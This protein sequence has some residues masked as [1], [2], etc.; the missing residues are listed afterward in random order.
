MQLLFFSKDTERLVNL[1]EKAKN[2][3][4]FNNLDPVLTPAYNAEQKDRSTIFRRLTTQRA[5]NR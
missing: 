4:L 5:D 1:Y 3:Y 2:L